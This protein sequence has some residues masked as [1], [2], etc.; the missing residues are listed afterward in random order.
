MVF[1]QGPKVDARRLFLHDFF[2]QTV[3]ELRHPYQ[4]CRAAIATMHGK[5]AVIAPIL[6]RWLGINLVCADN[7]DTDAFGTFTGEVPRTGTMLE[8]AR[9]KALAAIESSGCRIGIGSEG[10]F[11]PDPDVPFLA[12]GSEIV[13][14][15]DADQ[16]H[17]IHIYRKT[18]TNFDHLVLHPDQDPTDFLKRI[19]FPGHAII[20]KPEDSADP[21]VSV[22]GLRD[23]GSV[24]EH[25]RRMAGRSTTGHAI[26]QTDMRAHQNPTRMKS[27]GLVTKRLALRA[28]RLCPVCGLPGFG[29][30]DVVRGLACAECATPTSI[31]KAVIYSCRG[32]SCRLLRH[33][34]PESSRAD[35][36]YCQ[37]CNP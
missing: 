36:R 2:G 20:I 26:I 19:G 34:R 27:I 1:S 8:T 28:R 37:Q 35:P 30:V 32:C 31:I 23:P 18:R 25:I 24:R 14:L 17:E 33:Q 21:Y 12:S 11:G 13:L 10:S 6:R 15:Y 16:D 22:K 9:K 5:E 7:I 4:G 3:M 29:P